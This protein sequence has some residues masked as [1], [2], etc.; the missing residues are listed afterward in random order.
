MQCYIVSEI[1]RKDDEIL[2]GQNE[3]PSNKGAQWKCG[4]QY[5]QKYLKVQSHEKIKISY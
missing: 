3:T 4:P 2:D 1:D 5:F